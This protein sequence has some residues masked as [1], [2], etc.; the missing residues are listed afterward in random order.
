MSERDNTSIVKGIYD[1]F[2]KGDIPGLVDSFHDD[3]EWHLPEIENVP[4]SGSIKGRSNVE[5]FFQTLAEDQQ[6]VN[7]DPRE[8]IASGDRVVVL[9]DYT[10]HVIPTD[11]DFS[12]NWVH[13]WTVKEGKAVSFREYTDTYAVSIAH[14]KSMAAL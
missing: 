9:G 3:I 1:T 8:F 12:G 5:K 11:K 13:V 6:V 10:W 2:L 4:Y 14:Q 7:F